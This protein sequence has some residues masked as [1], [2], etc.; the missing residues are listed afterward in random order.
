MNAGGTYRGGL[1]RIATAGLIWGSIALFSR[2]VHTSAFV[3]VFWRVAFAA[4][5]VGVYLVARGRLGEL[6]GLSAR[7]KLGLVAMGTI[8]ALNWVLFFSAL[9]RTDVAVAVLLTYCGP[10]FVTVLAPA[11]THEKFDSRVLVPLALALA[12][13]AV[14]VGPRQ[15]QVADT[16]HLLGAALA[17]ASAFTYAIGVLNAKRL[18]K[19]IPATV[20]MLGE[21]ITAAV[22]LLPAVFLLPGPSMPAEWGSLAVLGVVHTAG[23]G[24]LFLSGLRAVRTDHAAI[25]TYA[26]P[27]SAVV[28]AALFLGEA[29]SAATLVGGTMV[30][31]GGILV[32]RME[33]TPGIEAPGPM[34]DVGTV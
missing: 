29:I 26:E 22:L 11:V 13:T 8:L 19:G 7:K 33:P 1:A 18:L 12:G 14:I 15:L 34:I 9:E 24:F 3:I 30:V 28:F 32:A 25:L 6:F 31:L 17:F 10:I 21:D 4:I 5:A 2:Q 16:T 20:Y 23:T 27:V